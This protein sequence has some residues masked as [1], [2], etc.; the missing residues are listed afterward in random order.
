MINGQRDNKTN[1]NL[2]INS[3]IYNFDK[4]KKSKCNMYNNYTT[5]KINNNK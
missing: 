1:V 3:A 5:T 2:R 4:N